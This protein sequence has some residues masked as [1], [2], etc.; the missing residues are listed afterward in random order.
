MGPARQ[1]ADSARG[2]G[3][4][5]RGHPLYQLVPARLEP[6]GDVG[7]G[8]QDA[9]VG[10]HAGPRR[11]RHRG[12]AAVCA[13]GLHGRQRLLRRHARRLRLAAVRG[14]VEPARARRAR[15]VLLRPQGS[16]VRIV[17]RGGR[18]RAPTPLAAPPRRR[19]ARLRRHAGDVR[20]P[21]RVQACQARPGG[22][23]ADDG[24]DGVARAGRRGAAHACAQLCGRRGWRRLP[25]DLRGQG[26]QRRH[27]AQPPR[28]DV[29]AHPV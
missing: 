14:Q 9:A 4:A 28:V 29:P 11:A 21:G 1:H 23:A 22:P 19:R 5:R 24:R 27:G 2:A 15:H 16:G 6:A 26:A 10:H 20:L 8:Q 7:Q 12:G 25:R 3:A 18:H 13:R 17:G